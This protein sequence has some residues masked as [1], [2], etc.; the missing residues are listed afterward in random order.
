[1]CALWRSVRRIVSQN[2]ED[3]RDGL[4]RVYRTKGDLAGRTSVGLFEMVRLMLV[5]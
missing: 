5:R 3:D 4:I 1:M 2:V